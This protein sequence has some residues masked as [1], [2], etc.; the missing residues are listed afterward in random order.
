MAEKLVIKINGDVKNY[1]AAL[2]E[3]KGETKDLEEGLTSVAKTSAIAF[4]GMGA[5]IVGAVG[6]AAKIETMTTQFE[7]LTGSVDTA[8]GLIK[9]LQKFSASTPFQLNGIAKASQV[10]LGFGFTADSITDKMRKIGDVAS[11]S[12]K[13]IQD[14]AMIYGQVA[15]AGKLTGERLLQLQERAIPIG[16]ALAKTMGVAETSIRDMVSKG[17]VD[18][19]TFEKAFASLSEEG[20]SAFNGMAKQSETLDG[21]IST[22]KDN[23]SL[24]AADIGKH[25]LPTFKALAIASTKGLQFLKDNPEFAKTA[26]TILKVGAAISGLVLAVT[27]AGIVVLKLSAAIVALGA[28]FLPATIAA[29]SFWVAVTGPIGIA[30]A[31]IGLVVGG[32]TA[33]WAALSNDEPKKNLKD[34]NSELKKK[35][36]AL[37]TINKQSENATGR[38]IAGYNAKK[39]AIQ[40][41]IEELKKLQ[42][43][44]TSE[45][46]LQKKE[47]AEIAASERKKERLIEERELKKELEDEQFEE[48]IERFLEK[49]ELMTASELEQAAL[50]ADKKEQQDVITKAK[51]LKAQGKHDQALALMANAK[52]KQRIEASKKS[53]TEEK[54]VGDA[55]KAYQIASAN[56][57]IGVAN[58]TAQLMT[59]IQGKQT[60]EAFFLAKAAAVAQV[61]V[62]H[63]TSMASATAASAAAAVPYA[64]TGA[65][66][67]VFA[68][69]MSFYQGMVFAN[70]GLSLGIIAAQTVQGMAKGG[71]VTG[72]IPGVDSV[73]IMAQQGELVSPRSNFEEVI[74]S[75]RAQR[76]AEELGGGIGGQT[77]LMVSYDSEEASQIVTIRQNEDTA[78]GISQDA[79]KEAV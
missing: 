68:A 60:K 16:P 14:I 21:R 56:S 38:E 72:G 31:G 49:D 32:V 55:R 69:N 36:A 9:D 58:K 3:V 45:E 64:V 19:A 22:L 33:L 2:E 25:L 40:G 66:P 65:G 13:P 73:P 53:L 8:T 62:N 39:E 30:V 6:E 76:A 67:A 17:K 28:A 4:A 78:L 24:L 42:E 79:F 20:G 50:R 51:A 47:E 12:G 74:G 23:F 63:S 37:E 7:V 41:E 34:V 29:S 5:A 15:A 43:V 35:Q 75:V 11:A 18:L 77:E 54:K 70:T 71:E 44:K 59:L 10:L 26:A 48:D 1:K 52:E 61:M 46:G 27:T 57:A